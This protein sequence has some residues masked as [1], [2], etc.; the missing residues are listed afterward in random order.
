MSDQAKTAIATKDAPAAIG[1]YSQAI[2]SGDMLF[3]SGQIGLD[4]TTGQLVPGGIAEQTKRVFENIKAVLAQAGLDV[5]H[6]VKTTV[7]LKSMSDFAAV[8]EIYATFLAPE[9]VVPPARSTVA[10]AG[11]PKDALVEIEVIAKAPA[12]A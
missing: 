6:V 10:V 1:P 3:A 9:G 7:Y 2:R 5:K 8:N 11:L 4:P 12:L